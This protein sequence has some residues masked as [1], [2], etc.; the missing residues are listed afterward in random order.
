MRNIQKKQP[1]AQ[2]LLNALASLQSIHQQDAT[3]T[4]ALMMLINSQVAQEHGRD[5][6]RAWCPRHSSWR[7]ISHTDRVSID[8]IK[9]ETAAGLSRQ[10][11]LTGPIKPG[12]VIALLAS[13]RAA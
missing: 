10:Q 12:V 1:H 11:G 2:H 5:Q 9:P 3:E 8:G 7:Q 6:L 4:T 13:G